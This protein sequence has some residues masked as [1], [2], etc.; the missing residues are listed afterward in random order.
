MEE[1]RELVGA[2]RRLRW[3]AKFQPSLFTFNQYSPREWGV[4]T[5][6]RPE[7]LPV[8]PP[9]IAIVTPSFNQ[10][11]FI[12]RT[13]QSVLD[14]Q[15]PALRY[16]VQDG[17][18]SDATIA[19]LHKYGDQLS[20]VSARDDGQA[21]AINL[22]FSRVEG[23]I[24]G[25]LNSDDTLLP[26]TLAYIANFFHDHPEIDFV[27]GHRIFVDVNDK[28]VGRMILPQHDR[29]AIKYFDFIPQETMFWRRR[30]WEKLGG[31]DAS[32]KFAMD[33]DFILRAHEAGFRFRRLPRFLGCFRVHNA[34]KSSS[35]TD[36]EMVESTRLRRRTHGRT[37]EGSEVT[38]AAGPYYRRH[39]LTVRAY[40][41]GLVRF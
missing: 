21:H 4:P 32:F 9:V 6:Y 25:W 31:V 15:Y 10:G 22:G 13:I 1:L 11:A 12:G 5:Y 18:S 36:I 20:W 41:L 35:W 26:G 37:L 28:D 34:Q 39:I 38:K 7:T 30:A 24:M 14:Q 3:R 29:E 17:G 33:W 16:T 8:N 23:E 27:Y 19:E 40:K 2:E